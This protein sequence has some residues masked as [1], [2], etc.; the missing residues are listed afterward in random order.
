MSPTFLESQRGVAILG[1]PG[2]SR[3]I[4]MV[5]LAA[6]EW[7]DGGDA[8]AMVSLK[9]Y[10]HQFYPDAVAYED[11]ALTADE[12]KALEALGHKLDR[13]ARAFGNMNV[14]TWDYATGKVEAATDPRGMA[15]GQVY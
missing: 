12:I 6:L 7:M 3:I 14:V 15:E 2:G 11:G 8:K 4:T 9:R 5:L 1:T 10:H 13:N